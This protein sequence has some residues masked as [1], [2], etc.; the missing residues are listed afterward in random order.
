MSTST[1]TNQTTDLPRRQFLGRLSA[2]TALTI[3]APHFWIKSS[4]A[5]SDQPI[6]LGEGRHRY[7]WVRGWAKLPEGIQFGNTHGA[8]VIDSQGRILMNT[9]SENAVMIFDPNGKYIK[10]WGKEWKGGSHGMGLYREGKNEFVFITHHSRHEFAKL[11]LD[12]EVVWVKGY[13]KESNVYQKPEDF[14]PTGIAIAP[15]GDFYVTDGYG[16]SWVHQ[17]TAK[18]DYVRSWGGKGAEQG[19]LNQPHG[20]WC[21][22]R[23]KEPRILVADRANSRL[24]WFSL[25]GE[26][27]AMLDQGLRR[28]SNF[29]QRGQD[30]VIADLQGRVTIIDGENKIIAHLGDNQDPEKR[31]KNPIPPDQWVD[32]QFISPHCPRWDAQGNLYILEWLSTGRIDKLKRLN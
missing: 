31:G 26:P 13:P 2:A 4:S 21:D 6:I 28:P 22:T 8:V 3:A 11:T 23:G 30:I 10:G 20:I 7:E 5:K 16:Q 32:G 17:Y 14:R 1:R 25:K 24:Q 29:H 15:N 9:D 18:G 27:I 12:G 19:K